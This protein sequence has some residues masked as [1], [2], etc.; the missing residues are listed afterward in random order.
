MV[1]KGSLVN[2]DLGSLSKPATVL[3]EKISDAVGGIAK[4]GQIV[5][6]AKAEADAEVI[7]ARARIE[8]SE[9]EERALHRMV[10]EEGV[11]QENMES[12]TAKALP[13]LKDDAKPDEIEKDWITNFFDKCRLISDQEMQ[14]L[15]AN[16]LAGQANA[17][18]SFS[19]RTI[20]TVA[21]LDKSDAKL[22]TTLCS[23]AWMIEILTPLIFDIEN[24][25][26]N[27]AGIDFSSLTHLDDLGLLTFSPLS[28][29]LRQSFPKN[30]T[31]HYYGRPIN[32][33]FPKDKD[34][35]LQIGK[36]LLSRTGQELSTISGSTPSKE[37]Y[38]YVLDEWQKKN[39]A[40]FCPVEGKE[41][42]AAW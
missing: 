22:F 31:V 3:I 4:P 42:H 14:T 9:I 21:A 10:R 32:I 6:V 24:K 5:R 28:G 17:P 30:F 1:E 35:D 29:F 39:Y 2:I 26:L 38:E 20:E 19:K 12:I 37:F 40:L 18:G 7:K 16:I 33:E 8:I 15:W 11:R 25:I 41:A 36:V 13:H 23:F 27:R 34:N